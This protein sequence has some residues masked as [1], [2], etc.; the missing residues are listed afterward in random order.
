MNRSKAQN[1]LSPNLEYQLFGEE[2]DRKPH[3]TLLFLCPARIILPHQGM[4]LEQRFGRYPYH[5]SHK[6]KYAEQPREKQVILPILH[7][8]W[9]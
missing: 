1:F 9:S 2:G 6:L 8:H 7:P 4:H 3:L 5:K